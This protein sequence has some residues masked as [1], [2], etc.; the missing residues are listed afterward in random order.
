[1]DR[2]TYVLAASCLIIC[3]LIILTVAGCSWPGLEIGGDKYLLS[4]LPTKTDDKG[5]IVSG[6][7]RE[8]TNASA[9]R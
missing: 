4:P 3:A 1:M 9:T 8:N 7:T 5:R 2:R 6:S